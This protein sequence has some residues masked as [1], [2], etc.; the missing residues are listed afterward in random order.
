MDFVQR[1]Q[2]VIR[3]VQDAIAASV[4]KQ[5]RNFHLDVQRGLSGLRVLV[6]QLL[7]RLGELP[8]QEQFQSGYTVI[9]SAGVTVNLGLTVQGVSF[10]PRR[11]HCVMRAARLGG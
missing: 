8:A 9:Q 7:L 6:A 3:F 1:R 4:D 2:A 10:R 5:K 11:H